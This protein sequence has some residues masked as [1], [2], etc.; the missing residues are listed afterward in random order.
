M[1]KKK[2]FDCKYSFVCRK[3]TKEKLDSY[4]VAAHIFHCRGQQSE[5]IDFIL[6]ID[7]LNSH[8]KIPYRKLNRFSLCFYFFFS[9]II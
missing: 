3:K 2:W 4:L 5:F 9:I 8:A 7:F 1:K 6:C